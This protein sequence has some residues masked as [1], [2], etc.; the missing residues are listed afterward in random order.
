MPID[1]D[2][3]RRL[4]ERIECAPLR[5]RLSLGVSSGD[6]RRGA[7]IGSL[8][9]SLALD[10]AAAGM[11]LRNTDESWCFELPAA[12]DIDP[13]FAL[14]ARWLRTN[15]MGSAWRDEL[16][17]VTDTHSH[18]IG[19]IERA[20]VRPLGI[21]TR[22]VHLVARNES[23]H[24]WVQQ[25]AFAK[26]TDPG[27]WD[28]TMGGLIAAD[29]STEQTLERETWEE[30]GLRIRDLRAARQFGHFTVRRPVDAGYMVEHIEMFE[31]T[32]PNKLAP[33]NQDGE[34]ERFEALSVEDLIERL[35]SDAFTL[36]AAMVL[37]KWI[38]A[39]RG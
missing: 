37:V 9:S 36:E 7:V 11:P 3:L 18:A 20:A 39:R 25:R 16:L 17:A 5:P 4:A 33:M 24:V 19:V 30:A 27:L 23:G 28:T 10:L 31:S 35:H 13:T 34:V 8:E 38:E 26:D 29:E 15:N 14:V 2:W 21:A 22:A 32:V 6:D 1:P 12:T